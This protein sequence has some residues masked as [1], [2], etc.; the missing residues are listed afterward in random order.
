VVAEFAFFFLNGGEAFANVGVPMAAQDR[1]NGFEGIHVFIHLAAGEGEFESGAFENVQGG[2]G[3]VVLGGGG[4]WDE[5][6]SGGGRFGCVVEVF[7]KSEAGTVAGKGHAR[8]F[9]AELL[10]GGGNYFI[11]GMIVLKPGGDLGT[12]RVGEWFEAG[13]GFH[14][15]ADCGFLIAD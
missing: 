8:D 13:E 5:F 11:V 1:G 12:L 6:G 4:E 3:E 2:A 9:D 15:I 14:I 7:E 10:A